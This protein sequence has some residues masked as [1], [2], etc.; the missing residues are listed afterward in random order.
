MDQLQITNYF[1]MNVNRTMSLRYTNSWGTFVN[2]RD[3]IKRNWLSG[4]KYNLVEI[5]VF[6]LATLSKVI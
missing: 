3:L 1:L 2:F 6:M 4:L 5:G